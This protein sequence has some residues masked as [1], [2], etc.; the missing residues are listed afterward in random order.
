MGRVLV[1]LMTWNYMRGAIFVDP[2]FYGILFLVAARAFH[3]YP[4]VSD[5]V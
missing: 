3:T 4:K 2:V 5:G 1:G